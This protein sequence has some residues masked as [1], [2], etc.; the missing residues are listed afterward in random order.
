MKRANNKKSNVIDMF[1]KKAAN[2]ESSNVDYSLLEQL[3]AKNTS[4]VVRHGKRDNLLVLFPSFC[5]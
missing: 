5:A 1:S 3:N 4:K 2:V